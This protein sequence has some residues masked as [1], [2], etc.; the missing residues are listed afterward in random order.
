MGEVQ[1]VRENEG[2]IRAELEAGSGVCRAPRYVGEELASDTIRGTLKMGVM[3]GVTW[4]EQQERW[5]VQYLIVWRG[6]A[7]LEAEAKL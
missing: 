3:D 4:S 2:E 1:G 5:T 7:L 6:Q